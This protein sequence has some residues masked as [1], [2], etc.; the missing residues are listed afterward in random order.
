MSLRHWQALQLWDD[1]IPDVLPQAV[2]DLQVPRELPTGND[3][4]TLLAEQ[5]AIFGEVGQ[6]DYTQQHIPR[7]A[8]AMQRLD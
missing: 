6:S 2:L 1:E 8:F 4:P 7:S 5:E 3:I